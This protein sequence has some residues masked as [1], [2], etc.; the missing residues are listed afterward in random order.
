[1]KWHFPQDVHVLFPRKAFHDWR[2]PWHGN[3]G[4]TR[5]SRGNVGVFPIWVKLNQYKEKPSVFN[6]LV[7]TLCTSLDACRVSSIDVTLPV[8]LLRVTEKGRPSM[9]ATRPTAGATGRGPEGT[10]SPT[11]RGP[12]RFPSPSKKAQHCL[13]LL[14]L[15]KGAPP[16]RGTRR[17]QLLCEFQ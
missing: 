16:K 11:P 6:L 10:R 15:T 14:P 12:A 9:S 3:L 7:E 13:L 5:T 4:L 8:W 1:M 17:R 2:S